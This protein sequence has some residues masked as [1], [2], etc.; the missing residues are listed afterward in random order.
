MKSKKKATEKSGCEELTLDEAMQFCQE[1]AS[2][3][4][5]KKSGSTYRAIYDM[6]AELKLRRADDDSYDEVYCD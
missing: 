4:K 5:F 6:L 1:M 2:C 3:G